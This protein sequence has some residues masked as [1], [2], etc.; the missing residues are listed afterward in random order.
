VVVLFGLAVVLR[1]GGAAPTRLVSAVK[2]FSIATL[3]QSRVCGMT[4]FPRP[5]SR[6][7]ACYDPA[8]VARRQAHM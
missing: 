7:I 8:A 3:C 1:L 2:G 5:V 4:T 6:E